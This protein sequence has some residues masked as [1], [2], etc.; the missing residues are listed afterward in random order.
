MRDWWAVWLWALGACL[1]APGAHHEGVIDR[2]AGDF[3]DALGAEFVGF[4][5][6]TGQM[7]CR[8]GRGESAWNGKDGDL[9]AGEEGFGIHRLGAVAT[10]LHQC[11]V[12]NGVAY[13]DRH[14]ISPCCALLALRA[15]E[16]EP[17]WRSVPRL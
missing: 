3:I 13:L 15:D 12:G 17:Q 6:K 14:L 8:T 16:L 2:D 10:G 1:L 4:F 9:S 11:D 7:T 5:H